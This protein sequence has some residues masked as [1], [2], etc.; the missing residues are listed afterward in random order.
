MSSH[1]LQTKL[2]WTARIWAGM[3]LL[4]LS[5]FIVGDVG[6][7]GNWPNFS[8]WIGLAFFPT[9]IITGLV[10]AFR[11]ELLGGAVT[12]LSLMGFY[13]WHF[14]VSGRLAAGPWFALIA[15]PGLLFLLLGLA[16]SGGKR[17]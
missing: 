14:A 15:A 1:A 6:R 12:V 17:S 9:G 2:R 5:A 8:Q 10:L 11:K 7:S 13:V 16:E 3:S 4:M